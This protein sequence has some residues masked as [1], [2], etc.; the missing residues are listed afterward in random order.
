[1]WERETRLGRGCLLGLGNFFCRA[2]VILIPLFPAYQEGLLWSSDRFLIFVG[3]NVGSGESSSRRAEN[4]YSC[5]S[6]QHA[7]QFPTTECVP[8]EG[9]G[10]GGLL[11]QGGGHH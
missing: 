1:M 2:I 11:R 10:R 9:D 4:F 8:T 6:D 5:L 3:P 7:V